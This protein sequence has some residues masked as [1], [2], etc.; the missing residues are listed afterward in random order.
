MVIH[1]ATHLDIVLVLMSEVDVGDND[2]TKFILAKSS[3]SE[4]CAQ[5]R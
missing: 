2:V 4:V 3:P 1:E 5:V